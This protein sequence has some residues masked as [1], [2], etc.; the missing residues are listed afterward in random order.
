MVSRR[1]PK[2]KRKD[3]EWQDRI[4]KNVEKEKV[5]L[6]HPNGLERFQKVVKNIG[7]KSTK[8]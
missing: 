1:L 6:S 8:K 2:P 7:K 4:A 5:Q 3:L